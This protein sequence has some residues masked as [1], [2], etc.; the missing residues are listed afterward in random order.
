MNKL[1]LEPSSTGRFDLKNF[2][3]L[4]VTF[5][6][7]S[8]IFIV[9]RGVIIFTL[10]FFSIGAFNLSGNVQN[11]DILNLN[12]AVINLKKA[13]VF[14][15]SGWYKNIVDT[16]YFYKPNIREQ[17]NVAF[18]YIYP[19]ASR[20]I[21][22]IFDLST[23]TALILTSNMAT[24]F[25]LFLMYYLSRLIGISKNAAFMGIF[26]YAAN[27]F[28]IFLTAGYSES[29]YVLVSTLAL[30]FLIK[31]K[32]TY[33]VLIGGM[34]SGIRSIGI[35][36]TLILLIYY[37]LIEKN[38]LTTSNLLKIFGLCIMSTWGKAAFM[39]HNYV[40]F[41]EPFASEIVQEYWGNIGIDLT[42]KQQLKNLINY[43]LIPF[44]DAFNLLN[45][46][47]IS[48]LV[49]YLLLIISSISLIGILISY[50]KK[51]ETIRNFLYAS[52]I[53]KKHELLLVTWS[54]VQIFLPLVVF[55]MKGNNAFSMGRYVLPMFPLYMLL[56]NMLEKRTLLY[57][58]ILSSFIFQMI[59]IAIGFSYGLPRNFYVF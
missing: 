22:N 51:N 38:K 59:I 19:M 40:R 50:F 8:S 29:T 25:S 4:F 14:W 20:V 5:A 44:K 34:L 55:G 23:D 42:I 3:S 37:F 21:R 17:F 43:I 58:M 35:F 39:L 15:D 45:P 12:N 56:G 16:G 1:T 54:L 53:D 30:I 10:L 47:V 11:S 26:L 31:K 49:V 27:P 7:I 57:S 52:I 33:A 9:S 32:Y 2:K 18:Y 48:I 6:Q 13:L 46:S 24:Y 36:F 28:S 41:K